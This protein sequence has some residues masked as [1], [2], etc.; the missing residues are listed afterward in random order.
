MKE[1]MTPEGT[2]EKVKAHLVAGG[3]QQDETSSPTVSTAAV[4][5]TMAIAAHER[6]HVMTM[7][8]E[9]ACLNQFL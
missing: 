2:V 6:R 7:D 3:N 8:V 5:V 4:L 9:T 1:K